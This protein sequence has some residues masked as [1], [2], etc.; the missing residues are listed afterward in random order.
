MG[1]LK[2]D[3]FESDAIWIR[4][5][6]IEAGRGFAVPLVLREILN[7]FAKDRQRKE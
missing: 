7:S 1:A 6:T 4:G 3:N 5:A 2:A